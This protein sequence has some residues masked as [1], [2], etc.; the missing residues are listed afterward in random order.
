MDTRIDHALPFDLQQ[1]A[2]LFARHEKVVQI[3]AFNHVVIGWAGEPCPDGVA[4]EWYFE[5]GWV[6]GQFDRGQMA[7]PGWLNLAFLGQ[8]LLQLVQKID[9][10]R[11]G[12]LGNPHNRGG[13]TELG[14]AACTLAFTAVLRFR[15]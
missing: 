15:C 14:F 4:E 12:A 8:L 5:G 7:R 3:Q 13:L 6:L 2:G 11:L 10:H 9:D 1:E